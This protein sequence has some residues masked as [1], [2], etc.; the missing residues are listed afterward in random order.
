MTIEIAPELH[1]D[2]HIDSSVAV[3]ELQVSEVATV[4]QDNVDSLFHGKSFTNW[5]GNQFCEPE[6]IYHL[7]NLDD[8]K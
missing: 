3:S 2:I 1:F 5:A 4:L 6:H 8:I 7:R